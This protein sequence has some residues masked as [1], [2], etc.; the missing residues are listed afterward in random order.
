MWCR[1]VKLCL[2]KCSANTRMVWGRLRDLRAGRTAGGENGSVE[3]KMWPSSPTR[4][5][6]E[7][8]AQEAPKSAFRDGWPSRSSVGANGIRFSNCQEPGPPVG[9]AEVRTLPLLSTAT[10]RVAVG[11]ET[12]VICTEPPAFASRQDAA[13]P[14]GSVDARTL[15][16]RFPAAQSSEETQSTPSRS[17]GPPGVPTWRQAEVPPVGSV[18]TKSRPPRATATQSEGVPQETPRRSSGSA[19]CVTCQVPESGS[20]EVST[21]PAAL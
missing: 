2:Q 20:V 17:P 11:H 4:A 13:G 5:Q 18:E 19:N 10:Q 21:R 8:E 6:S 16:V 12:S 7:V 15:P 3:V 9:S 14:S 1:R